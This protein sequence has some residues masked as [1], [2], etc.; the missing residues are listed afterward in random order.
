MSPS[1]TARKGRL[2]PASAEYPLH[3]KKDDPDHATQSHADHMAAW[4]AGHA[5]RHRRMPAST[6]SPSRRS[7]STPPARASSRS[8]S[9]LQPLDDYYLWCDHRAWR[10]AAEI[11]ARR[12]PVETRR[13]RLVRRHL[14]LRMGLLEAA[15]LAAP[16]PG[17]ARPHSS[18]AF[19]HCDYGRGRS[20]RHPRL[21][22]RPAQHLRHGPQMDVE[23]S[24]RRTSARTNSSPSSTRCCRASATRC[25]GRYRHL[26]P[27]RRAAL[28]GVGRAT[29]PAS[30]HPDS[31]RRFRCALGRDRRR[32]ARLGD[33]VNVI[34]TSTCIM[35][36][37]DTAP[38]DPRR[39]RRR[40]GL[41]PSRLHRHRSRAV[42]D[43]R[44][45]R[46]HR[47]PGRYDRRRTLAKGLEKLSGR[48]DRTAAPHLGQRR[49]HRSGQSRNSAASRS[50]GTSPTPP[51]DEL[52]AAIEGTAFHTR[53]ILERMEEHGVPVDRVIN[54][55]GIPQ[56]Q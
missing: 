53:V 28:A 56:P 12:T 10:E 33:V 35:A 31:R 29:R 3:R 23:R 46:R 26:R 49:S 4:S 32:R 50:A 11:T 15:A 45:L 39:L 41:R 48:A 8:M 22:Q 19:E 27:D 14:L 6:A 2:G 51:Q 7:P 37:G 42:G 24:A 43:R 55:G 36:I 21:G 9:S 38:L 52:F 34:G 44:H 1:S 25:N 18:R 13:H 16:Q 20:V 40:A 17:Q 54:G 30:R 5:A 47:P